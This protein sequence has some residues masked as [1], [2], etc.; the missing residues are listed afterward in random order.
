MGEEVRFVSSH[1]QEKPEPPQ[2]GETVGQ[3]PEPVVRAV[4]DFAAAAKTRRVENICQAYQSLKSVANGLGITRV[5]TLV[6]QILG[7]SALLLVISAYSHE[8]CF[9]CSNGVVP[10][11]MCAESERAVGERECVRCNSTGLAPCEFC[12]GTAWVGNDVIP[13]EILRAVWQSRLKHAHHVLEKYAR[14]Y[15]PKALGELAQRDI[16]DEQRREAITRTIR[17]AAQLKAL[18]NSPAVTDSTQKEHLKSVEEKLHM[19]LTMLTWG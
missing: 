16:G 14:N 19:C 7:H 4:H 3:L 1:G 13:K 2:K 5:L 10:C 12:E 18:G 17:L 15:T 11:E 8:R 6:D 9:M